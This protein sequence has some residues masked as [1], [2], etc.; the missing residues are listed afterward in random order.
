VSLDIIGISNKC[1]GVL[2]NMGGLRDY[3]GLD[4]SSTS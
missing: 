2:G 4:L 3:Y 1:A